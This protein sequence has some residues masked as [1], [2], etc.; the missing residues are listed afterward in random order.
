MKVTE[1]ELKALGFEFIQDCDIEEIWGKGNERYLIKR[2][3]DGLR[4][5]L[6]YPLEKR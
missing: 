1:E 3:E 5:T 4:I 2:E 6:K